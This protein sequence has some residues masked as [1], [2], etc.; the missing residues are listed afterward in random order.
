MKIVFVEHFFYFF[1]ENFFKRFTFMLETHKA[2]K[3]DTF[4]HLRPRGNMNIKYEYHD[5][6]NVE[7]YNKMVYM[8]L[9]QQFAHVC[10]SLRHI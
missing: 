5:D 10:M 3:T 2:H 6:S 1:L 9:V 7:Q 8:C 4:A